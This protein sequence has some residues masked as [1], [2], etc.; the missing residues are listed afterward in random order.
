MIKYKDQQNTIPLTRFMQQTSL[1]S[2]EYLIKSGKLNEQCERLLHLY[3]NN[4]EGL[5]DFQ[6]SKKLN[7]DAGTVSA[8]RNDLKKQFGTHIIINNGR[9]QNGRGRRTGILWKL[10]KHHNLEEKL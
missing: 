6:S 7:L 3:L 5:T 10:N 9:S 1:E 8:R 2:Y 4:S